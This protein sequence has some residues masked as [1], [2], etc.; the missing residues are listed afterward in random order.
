VSARVRVVAL[1]AALLVSGCA[2]LTR[3]TAPPLGT[4]SGRAG[5]L[6][7]TLQD[8]RLEA[9]AT[10]TAQGER[11]RLAL[12]APDGRARLEVTVPATAFPDE[13]ACLADASERMGSAAGLERTRRHPTNLG[14]RPGESLEA[15]RGDWHVWAVAVCDGG[16]QYRI[17]FTAASPAPVEVVDVW[18]TLVQSA[19]IGGEA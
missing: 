10:W 11:R 5:W 9:P 19:R 6:T 17:F 18:R 1:S 3:T 12:A 7:Y 4:P 8:L 2:R 13:R 15:D 14:G 16:M